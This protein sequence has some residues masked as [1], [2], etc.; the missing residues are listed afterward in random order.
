[1][2][3]KQRTAWRQDTP[4]GMY[5]RNQVQTWGEK[6]P[7]EIDEFDHFMEHH[8]ERPCGHSLAPMCADRMDEPENWRWY[9]DPTARALRKNVRE[10]LCQPRR[11]R[12]RR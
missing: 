7:Y 1:M 4:T 8:G 6:F 12:R 10:S 3:F 11:R 5:F 9:K 2:T